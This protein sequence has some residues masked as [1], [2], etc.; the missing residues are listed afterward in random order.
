VGVV[1]RVVSAAILETVDMPN[2]YE[3]A[4]K[5]EA[6]EYPIGGRICPFFKLV[7]QLRGINLSK[8]PKYQSPRAVVS[9]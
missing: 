8:M 5:E 2:E 1:F 4:Y 3:G 9:I 7:H 6:Q